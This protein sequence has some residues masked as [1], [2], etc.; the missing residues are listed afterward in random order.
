MTATAPTEPIRH[1]T[2]QVA[3]LHV[4]QLHESGTNPRR[5]FDAKALAELAESIRQVGVLQPLLV[6]RILGAV[7]YKDGDITTRDRYE[8]VAGARRFRAAKEAGL[9][10]VPCF[11]RTLTDAQVLEVQ[12]VENLQRADLHP[13]DEGI[14]YLRLHQDHGYSVDDLAGKLNKSRSWV[15]GRMQLARLPVKVQTLFFDGE[16]DLSH[17][18]L[19]SRI[20]LPELAEKAA[21]DIARGD[22]RGKPMPFR[23]AAEHVRINYQCDLKSA[24]FPQASKDLLP[25]AGACGACPKRTGNQKG[26]FE[27][28]DGESA[29]VCT[30]PKCFAAKS[31]AYFEVQKRDVL[32]RGGEVLEGKAARDAI[33]S[34][35]YIDPAAHDY[36]DGKQRTYA[37]LC[38]GKDLAPVLLQ[39]RDGEAVLRWKRADVDRALGIEKPA[40]SKASNKP[41]A[42]DRAAARF[43][44]EQEVA[45]KVAQRRLVAVATI[46]SKLKPAAAWR[47]IIRNA[48]YDLLADEVGNRRGLNLIARPDGGFPQFQEKATRDAI[49]KMGVAE[50]QA[51]AIEIVANACP[52]LADELGV[53]EKELA[54]EAKA[55][56]KAQQKAAAKAAKGAKSRGPAAEK[57]LAKAMAKP[58]KKGKAGRGKAAQEPEDSDA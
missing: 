4:N 53:D 6:R 33:Y 17:A 10:E 42:D 5:A 31:R 39:G 40:P 34:A 29:D 47:L 14:G 50:L 26:L 41:D 2:D 13:L 54:R 8:V 3:Y 45:K 36:S 46:A 16:I 28:P 18:Q 57:A 11:V 35:Q 37:Q 9:L 43:R 49:E 19:C 20:P 15:Y 21:K 25:E 23:A 1:A 32:A 7:E 30:D 56:L 22:A 27:Q 44:T 58:A 24:P 52:G 51:L 12:F 48:A 55:E 38:K